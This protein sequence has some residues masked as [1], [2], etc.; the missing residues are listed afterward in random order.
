MNTTQDDGGPAFPRFVP[1]GHY[2]GS[3]DFTGMSLRD[4]FAGM[5]LTGEIA[6]SSTALACESTAKAAIRNQR[7]IEQQIA[8]NCY[9]MAD[10]MIAARKEAR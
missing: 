8:W 9:Q 5:A 1:D 7:T 2:N 10:A 3:V 4:W 6:S